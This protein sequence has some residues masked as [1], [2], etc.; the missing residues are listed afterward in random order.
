MGPDS[1]SV[2]YISHYK[3]VLNRP[4]ATELRWELLPLVSGTHSMAD[5]V[6]VVQREVAW[7]GFLSFDCDSLKRYLRRERGI[8]T[9]GYKKESV[10]Q[11]ATC[12]CDIAVHIDPDETARDVFGQVRKNREH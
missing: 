2:A 6:V 7:N 4:F 8:S 1:V 3:P 11:L 5:T 9:T 10:V 12:A